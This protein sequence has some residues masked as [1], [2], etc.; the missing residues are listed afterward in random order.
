MSEATYAAGYLLVGLLVMEAVGRRR[1]PLQWAETP[2]VGTRAV[3]VLLW[4]VVVLAV[5]LRLA[6]RFRGV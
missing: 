6:A 2:P 4:P 1:S 5:L 3:V